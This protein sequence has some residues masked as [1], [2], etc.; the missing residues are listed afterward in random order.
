MTTPE[1]ANY[2]IIVEALY[3]VCTYGTSAPKHEVRKF[4]RPVSTRQDNDFFYSCNEEALFVGM[5]FEGRPNMV[6]M[7][8][9]KKKRA[10]YATKIEESGDEKDICD[11]VEED[12]TMKKFLLNS[13]R[14][15]FI[16]YS[17]WKKD[18]QYTHTI[19]MNL[20]DILLGLHPR[21]KYTPVSNEY[22][23]IDGEYPCYYNLDTYAYYGR[24]HIRVLDHITMFVMELLV[25][26]VTSLKTQH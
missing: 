17:R 14:F 2:F 16:N 25:L 15:T 19:I 10:W 26:T 11:L 21:E 6:S 23:A 4:R 13:D 18:R 24:K 9:W 3:F 12:V 22:K 8:L 1:V 7:W 5:A 20:V